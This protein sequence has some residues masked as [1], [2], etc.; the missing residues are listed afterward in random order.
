MN[1]IL[2]IAQR[3]FLAYAKTVGFWL[4]LLAFPLF[5]VLGG[6]VPL[7]MRGADPVRA[8]VLIEEGPAATGLAAAVKGALAADAERQAERAREAAEKAAASSGAPPG[9]AESAIAS[10]TRSRIR[11]VDAPGD[12]AGAETGAAQEVVVRR[13]LTDETPKEQRLDAV[14]FLSRSEQGPAARVWAARAT[15]DTVEDFV[16]R[17]L[18]DE[19]RDTVLREAGIDA[20]VVERADAFRP[21]INVF[22][23][24][25]AGGGEVSFKDRLP[26]IIGLAFSFILWSL[27]I[28]G[29]SILLN[30]V[31]EEKS[32]KI[33]EVLLS[34]ASATEILTGKVLGVAMLTLSV[35][36]V[37][38]GIGAVGLITA[39]PS[40]AADVASVLMTDGLIFY[41]IGYIVG[42]YL[43]YAVL[44]AA[45]GAFCETPRDAQTLMGPIMMVLV[46]PL[47]VVQMALVNPDAPAVK[48]L[49][50]VPFFTPFLMSARAP[51]GPP[52]IEIIG[53]MAGMFA[54]AL[55]MVWLAGRAFRA[56]ALSDV[57]LSWKSFGQAISGGGR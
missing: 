1:R 26:G 8:V 36:V 11:F 14:V 52:L 25:S 32:N 37:W 17:A 9:A 51:S 4:S 2:L 53:T 22:S 31:M 39:A 20:A 18:R 16:S 13:Y 35:L 6:A 5:A 48:F 50:W 12:L 28:T 27:I 10:M 19:N 41:F 54:V 55:L 15:D 29:A 49:S 24:R 3:E 38:G 46:V 44:F 43:M 56:G 21:E 42:G 30:S 47:L 23:P 45:I 33:L 7:L 57:K 40:V 34:S